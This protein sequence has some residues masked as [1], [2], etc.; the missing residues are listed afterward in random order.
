MTNNRKA[1]LD[2]LAWSEGTSN[3]P[4]TRNSGYD[5]IV[6]GLDGKPEIFTDY[7]NHPFANGRPA[8]VFNKQG[9][10]STASGR[11]Q[12]LYRWYT[13]YAKMLGLRDFSP[14]SQDAI[15]LQ[16]IKERKALSAIDV[17]DI[18]T[19]INLC[20]NIWAS[21]PGNDYGQRQHNID[22]LL[23]V[24]VKSGGQLKK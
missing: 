13:P 9:Q 3:H 6:T 4:I 8:K 19:A 14:A 17:G 10:S 11:Y 23:D 1:F 18:V 5:V 20:S 7:S 22:Y 12:L 24:Y 16:Q 21:L 2:M 15:A